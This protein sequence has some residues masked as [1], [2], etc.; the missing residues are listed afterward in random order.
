MTSSSVKECSQRQFDAAE[1][2]SKKK[3][4]P[5]YPESDTRHFLIK[6]QALLPY[7][8]CLVIRG[9]SIRHCNA[10]VPSG[11]S[12]EYNEREGAEK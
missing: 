1:D 12:L 4:P 8:S 11:I 2:E 3:L 9:Q 6:G 7:P 10:D 5:K